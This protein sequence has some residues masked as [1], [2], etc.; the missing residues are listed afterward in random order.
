[1]MPKQEARSDIQSHHRNYLSEI[2][3]DN[4]KLLEYI[5]K[6]GD[7]LIQYY[8]NAQNKETLTH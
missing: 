2:E 7:I 6:T 5:S 1:M 3:G 8:T 4:D